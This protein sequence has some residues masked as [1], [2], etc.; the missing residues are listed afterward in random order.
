MPSRK[1]T[2]PSRKKVTGAMKLAGNIMK[3]GRLEVATAIAFTSQ[4][5]SVDPTVTPFVTVPPDLF[6]RKF[7]DARVGI[8]DGQI[9]AFKASLKSL[10]PEIATDIDSIPENSNQEIE[11]VAFFVKLALFGLG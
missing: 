7:N 5:V 6:D 11:A 3:S 1:S 2:K 10:L 8:D 9:K 4:L